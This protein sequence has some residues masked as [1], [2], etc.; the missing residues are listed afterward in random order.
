MLLP[1]FPVNAAETDD[2]GVSELE[3]SL[4]ADTRD[5]LSDL[6]S[7]AGTV[8]GFDVKKL[9]N[10]VREEVLSFYHLP[11]KA[12][13]VMLSACAVFSLMSSLG[14]D[15]LLGNVAGV[16]S[17]AVVVLP[18]F[19]SMITNLSYVCSVT[20]KF[21]LAA[22]PV[23]VVLFISSGLAASGASYGP[24]TLT[25]ANIILSMG[26]KFI[27]PVLS[28]L[29]GLSMTSAFSQIKTAKITENIYK[30]IKWIMVTAVSVFSGLISVQSFVTTATDAAAMKTAKFFASSAIPIVGGALG[31]GM[32]TFKQSLVLLKSGAG[33]FGVLA[34]IV[35]FLPLILRGSVWYMVC[36][37]GV[38]IA[39]IFSADAV[40]GFL[41]SCVNIVKMVLAV[42]VSVLIAAVVSAAVVIC[43]GVG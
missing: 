3:E 14:S 42:A 15:P 27:V 8:K 12:L 16:I 31:D 38:V 19:A 41:S 6:G 34:V 10:M 7:D 29:V 17:I 20:G 13:A 9:A 36:S 24:L 22:I 28:V 21:L 40:S 32:D 5:K 2:F 30:P 25:A 35:I 33:A 18:E 4:D 37:L 23:Y 11:L 43:V 1:V 39:D 26:E